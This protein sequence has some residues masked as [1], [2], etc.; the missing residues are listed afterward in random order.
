MEKLL[1]STH[2]HEDFSAS[3]L[4]I[5]I[6]ELL[7]FVSETTRKHTRNLYRLQF[8]IPNTSVLDM[9]VINKHFMVIPFHLF[10]YILLFF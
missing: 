2:K 1:T 8:Q 9:V 7:D 3:E 6:S 10:T 5:R 4:E